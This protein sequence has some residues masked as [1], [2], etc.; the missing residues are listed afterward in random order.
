[1]L[2]YEPLVD[3]LERNLPRD[4]LK[5]LLTRFHAEAATLFAVDRIVTSRVGDLFVLEMAVPFEVRENEGQERIV[6]VSRRREVVVCPTAVA[7]ETVKSGAGINGG[8]GSA[9]VGGISSGTSASV[10]RS[11]SP[12]PPAPPP[13]PLQP[14][15][16]QTPQPQQPPQ[17]STPTQQTQPE[18]PVPRGVTAAVAAARGLPPPSPLPASVKS[19]P[20]QQP[21]QPTQP[22]QPVSRGLPATTPARG[23]PRTG[24][25]KWFERA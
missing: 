4:K 8:S 17:P 25:K 9:G 6:D 3:G 20:S 12:S 11:A 21:T 24:A 2:T 19:S 22:E 5:I 23:V 18:Q 16:Q 15:R 10:S 14:T 13:T 1:M 7:A